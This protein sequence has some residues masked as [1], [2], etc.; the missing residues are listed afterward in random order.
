MRDV[1]FSD[2]HWYID[3]IEGLGWNQFEKDLDNYKHKKFTDKP[4]AG[5]HH[6]LLPS[7]SIQI[8]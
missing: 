1:F 2:N 4:A 8:K 5:G 3:R 7:L 6:A